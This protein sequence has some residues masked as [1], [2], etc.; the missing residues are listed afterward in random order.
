ML[1]RSVDHVLR[2]VEDNNGAE[3]GER[4]LIE[5]A[6][7]DTNGPVAYAAFMRAELIEVHVAGTDE[8][9]RAVFEH[10][11]FSPPAWSAH[12]R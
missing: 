7:F 2:G 12:R 10:Q 3:S 4:H 11:T 5:V 6:L 1:F 9:T 8:L